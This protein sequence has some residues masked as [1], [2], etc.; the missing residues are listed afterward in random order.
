MHTVRN[1]CTHFVCDSD[2]YIYVTMA[3]ILG[4][5]TFYGLPIIPAHY[6]YYI[7]PVHIFYATIIIYSLLYSFGVTLP[8]GGYFGDLISDAIVI[9][10]IGFVINISQA[11][12]LAK[13][14]AYSIHPDQ[15]RV[16]DI[17]QL[18]IP[19]YSNP[20]K[21]CNSLTLLQRILAGVLC[22]WRHELRRCI[23]WQLPDCWSSQSHCPSRCD[24]WEHT[25]GRVHLLRY[26]HRGD[27]VSGVTLWTS[28]QCT[29]VVG[30]CIAIYHLY[31]LYA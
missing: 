10:I 27:T 7:L 2:T 24:G 11:K 21:L 29:F 28:A 22:L 20:L 31:T 17:Y 19:Q 8:K 3:Y 4:V 25:T 1:W 9:A 14:N 26:C 16:E 15:V 30:R 6:Q 13:K 23:F 18:C 5:P 12:L